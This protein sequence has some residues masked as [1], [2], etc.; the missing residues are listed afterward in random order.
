MIAIV[1]DSDLVRDA[2]MSLVKSFGYAAVGFLSAEQ[3]LQSDHLDKAS[4]LV[5]DVQMP[6]LSGLDLQDCLIT[7]GSAM[8]VIVVGVSRREYPSAGNKGWCALLPCKAV[9]G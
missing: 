1:D 7:R 2:T 8:P 3:F 5:T 6:G 4:C 9:P